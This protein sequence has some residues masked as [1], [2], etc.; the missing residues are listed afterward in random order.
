VLASQRSQ[1]FQRRLLGKADDGKIGAMN[2]QQQPR[3]FRDGI[4]IVGQPRAIGG[5]DLAQ[6]SSGFCHHVRHAE[7]SA[8]FHQL[9]ARDDDLA[10]FSERV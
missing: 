1:I 8:D 2:A 3:F 10:A 4:F 9:A 5:A 7:R 6:H